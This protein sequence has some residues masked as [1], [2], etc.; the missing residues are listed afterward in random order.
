VAGARRGF[1]PAHRPLTIAMATAAVLLAG[2][3]SAAPGSGTFTGGGGGGGDGGQTGG[4]SGHPAKDSFTGSVR[5]A[6]GKYSGATGRVHLYLR[7]R[8][9]GVRRSL[10]LTLAPSSCRAGAKCL[11]LSGTLTGTLAPGPGHLPDT[12][13]G[14]LVTATGTVRP[15][16][17]V[18][19]RGGV[20]GTGFIRRGQ[21]TLN[22]TLSGPSVSVTIEGLSAAVN[23]FTSP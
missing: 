16:G 15:L 22:L 11:R 23:G 14:Y 17:M 3:G 18:T 1:D 2:C 6:S 9:H 4:G 12:G 7:P 8:G 19:A 10:T 20:Q 5:S 21:E 13:D